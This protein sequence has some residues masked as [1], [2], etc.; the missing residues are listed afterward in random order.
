MHSLRRVCPRLAAASAALL[1]CGLSLL[2]LPVAAQASLTWSGPVSIDPQAGG[3]PLNRVACSSLT[4]CTAVDGVGHAVTFNPESPHGVT[5]ATIGTHSLSGIAC[6]SSTQCTAVD[7]SGNE[8]T[9]DPQSTTGGKPLVVDSKGIPLGVACPSSTQCTTVDANG[10]EITFD[11]QSGKT[12]GST[13]IDPNGV[14]ISVQCP[15]GSPTWCVAVDISGAAIGFS[16]TGAAAVQGPTQVDSG[17]APVVEAAACSSTVSSIQ[18]AL[19]DNAAGAIGFKASAGSAPQRGSSGTILQSNAGETVPTALSCP[20]DSECVAVDGHGNA[21][22]FDPASLV[23][24]VAIPVDKG[25]ALSDV[26][27]PSESQCTAVDRDGQEVTFNPNPQDTGTPTPTPVDGHSNLSSLAC[28]S[29]TQC[30]AV[31]VGGTEVTFTPGSSSTPKSGSVDAAA[32]GVYGVACPST[33]QC[34]AVDNL[35]DEVTFN[36]DSPGKPTPT[37]IAGGHT[38]YAV[39]CPSVT[40]CTA[41]DD[42]GAEVTFNPEAAGHPSAVAVDSGHALLALACPST[43][44]CTAVDDS[45]AEVTFDPKAPGSPVPHLID[46]TPDSAITCATPTQCTAVD[47]SGD[48]VTFNPQA[49]SEASALAI[50]PNHRFAAIACRTVGDCVAI[51]TAGRAIEGDPHLTVAW[52]TQQ[53]SANSLAAVQCPSVRDCAV[54]DGPG[55][56][57][58]G[59]SGPLPPVPRVAS[60]PAAVGLALQGQ[61]LSAKRGRWLNQADFFTYQWERCSASGARCASIAGAASASYRLSAA[62]VGHRIRLAVVA[63]NSGGASAPSLSPSTRTVQLS[64]VVTH[65]SISGLAGG[66][67]RLML[68][69]RAGPG[70]RRISRMT[71]LLPAGLTLHRGRRIAVR[72]GGTVLGYANSGMGSAITIV[73]P[74]PATEATVA[75]S[76]PELQAAARLIRQSR[77]PQ[78]PRLRLSLTVTQQDR[79]V[80]HLS[81]PLT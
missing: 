77:S 35:G 64:L 6:P 49:P 71:I 48:E 13:E 29:I 74:A 69:L 25:Q 5:T 68:S 32:S 76:S 30:T 43:K 81:P 34:T 72:N 63:G 62:D 36:P 22:Y 45:G 1:F 40:Q 17:Q 41:V 9:F 14:L 3:V 8:T 42:G 11:P 20:S 23:F 39:A 79:G 60:R 38:L 78:P 18:C 33:R 61:M 19:V 52:S 37:A 70:G 57:F 12:L 26:A 16:P 24:G 47:S 28:P 7:I 59:S 54:V 15:G 27:C 21:S 2:A 66:A 55:N 73:L 58:A 44:Q 53:V 80:W 4:Q 65:A 75:I 10:A 46:R 56:A 67:P 31:D 51:D 50:D